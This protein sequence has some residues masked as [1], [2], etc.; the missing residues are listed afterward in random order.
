[1]PQKHILA[2]QNAHDA[3]F[4]THRCVSKNMAEFF[5]DTQTMTLDWT[6]TDG[7]MDGRYQGVILKLLDAT[8]RII[9][10]LRCEFLSFF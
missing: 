5:T 7:W 3:H 8:K 10:L 9:S 4:K 2:S 1:M 6:Q